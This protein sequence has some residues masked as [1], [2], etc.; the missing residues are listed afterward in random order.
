MLLCHCPSQTVL[1]QIV[2]KDG[3]VARHRPGVTTK[4]RNMAQ[5]EFL[6]LGHGGCARLKWVRNA[7][8]I[9]R[10]F[11]YFRWVKKRASLQQLDS[12]KLTGRRSCRS[13]ERRVGKECR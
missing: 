1:N 7:D 6:E 9:R 10:K 8:G 12:E 11:D 4:S 2:G 5:Q 3:A 13:E